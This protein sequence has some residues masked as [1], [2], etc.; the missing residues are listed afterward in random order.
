MANVIPPAPLGTDATADRFV[1]GPAA[2]V[3]PDAAAE[4]RFRFELAAHPGSVAHARRLTRARLS[5]WALCEDTCDTAALVVSELV[6]NAIVHAAGRRVVCEL[7]DRDDLVRIAVRDEGRAPGEPHPTPQ[8]PEEEHGRG[9]LLIEAMCRAWGAQD[10]GPGLLV[11]ADVPRGVVPA[12]HAS[13]VS[14]PADTA[15]RL[16]TVPPPAD[17]ARPLNKVPPPADRRSRDTAARSD[18][19]WS[20]KKPPAEDRGNGVEAAHRTGAVTVP[21]ARRGRERGTV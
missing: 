21:A 16:N 7:H 2:R 12:Q 4:R 17:S 9:L 13:E 3:R 11:W 5:G 18:L 15:R 14:P 1:A 8:R 20:A 19:G 6:T 10:A